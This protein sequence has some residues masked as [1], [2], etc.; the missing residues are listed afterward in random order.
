MCEHSDA[1]LTRMYIIFSEDKVEEFDD[2][3]CQECIDK[4]DENYDYVV[5][6]DHIDQLFESEATIY[7]VFRKC[8]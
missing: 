5:F 6:E 2:R 1:D 8:Y 4:I 3:L 7:E